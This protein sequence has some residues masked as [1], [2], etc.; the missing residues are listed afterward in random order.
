MDPCYIHEIKGIWSEKLK[1]KTVAGPDNC[2]LFVTVQKSPEQ[3]ARYAVMRR[4][5]EY[6][7]GKFVDREDKKVRAF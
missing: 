5:Y 3:R 7:R 6:V 2:E 4:L 1:A